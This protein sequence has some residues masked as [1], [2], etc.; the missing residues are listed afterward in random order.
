MMVMSKAGGVQKRTLQHS[1]HRCPVSIFDREHGFCHEPWHERGQ[2]N[3]RLEG[4]EEGE[5]ELDWNRRRG[6][7]LPFLD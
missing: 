3:V 6:C 5:G 1:S 7:F 2:M 4:L